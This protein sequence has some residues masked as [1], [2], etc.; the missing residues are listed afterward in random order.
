ML[1]SHVATDYGVIGLHRS[2]GAQCRLHQAGSAGTG[3]TCA[4]RR[5]PG[6]RAR[7]TGT[8]A[9]HASA[10]SSLYNTCVDAAKRS[11]GPGAEDIRISNRQVIARYSH[12]EIV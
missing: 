11:A 2:T 8:K 4:A 1:N 12:V 10:W 6:A 9:A 7:C 5:T 3:A